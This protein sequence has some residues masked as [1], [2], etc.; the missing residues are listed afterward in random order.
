M[1]PIRLEVEGFASFRDRV[2][3]DFVDA[4]L[5]VLFG[6]TGAGKSSV[7]DALT[8]ALYGSVPRYDDTRL[9][10]PVISQ[11][12]NEARV[13][14]DFSVGG[15]EY[16]AVRVVRRTKTGATTREARLQRGDDV[17][18]GSAVELTSE[19]EK[20]LGLPFQHFTRCVVLPQ[21]DFADFLHAKAG[22][23]QDLIIKLLDLDVYRR[24]AQAANQRAGEASNRAKLIEERLNGDL[25][26][27]TDAALERARDRVACLAGLLELLEEGRAELARLADTLRTAE[28][29]ARAS[30]TKATLLEGVH[31]PDGIEDLARALADAAS[32]A[33]AAEAALDWAVVAREREEERRRLLPER[34]ALDVALER[35]ANRD[36]LAARLEPA[37][38]RRVEAE[39]AVAEAGGVLEAAQ[40]A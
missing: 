32:A 22:D 12:M 11:G 1:R 4:D 39:R 29:A 31:V 24:I 21:G 37:G 40:S 27:V 7:I 15:E 9:V 6:A 13:R 26:C 18:A 14:L 20:L 16:T 38:R 36:D 10:A 25:A 30:A 8:F 19:V 17:C 28:A 33:K 5:F 2:E 23:R 34:A 35:H 3:I